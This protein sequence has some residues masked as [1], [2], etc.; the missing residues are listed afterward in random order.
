M[1]TMNLTR[2]KQKLGL[3]SNTMCQGFTL[4]ELLIVIVTLGLIAALVLPKLVAQPEKARMMQAANSMGILGRALE[5]KF[6]VMD[7]WLDVN[8]TGNLSSLGFS[9]DPDT[10]DWNFTSPEEGLVRATRRDGSGNGGSVVP[11]PC[12]AGDTIELNVGTGAYRGCDSADCA[13]PDTGCYATGGAYS[14][15]MILKGGAA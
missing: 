12:Q 1:Q 2:L 14:A 10:P 8:D 3:V 4:V 7:T 15:N 6:Q 11:S 5:V 9:A 13:Y